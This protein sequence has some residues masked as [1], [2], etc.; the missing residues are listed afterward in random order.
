MAL[1]FFHCFSGADATTSFFK[2]SKK[3]WFSNWMNSPFKDLLTD[4][5]IKL[6]RCPSANDVVWAQS[7]TLMNCILTDS[8]HLARTNCEYC[9]HRKI[10][11][12][13]TCSV[14]RTKQVGCGEI[15]SF[16]KLHRRQSNGD[17]EFHLRLQW[18]SLDVSQQL[19]TAISIC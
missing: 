14:R 18:T 15:H 4:T 17:G 5:F 8:K 16:N 7:S 6:G 11:C 1:L 10:R 12:S 3:D 19:Q 13:N 2:I 9:H